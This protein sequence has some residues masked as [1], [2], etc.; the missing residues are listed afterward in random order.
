[1]NNKVIIFFG[2]KPR[3]FYH[4]V[5]APPTSGERRVLCV[6]R[7][8]FN[9]EERD[10]GGKKPSFLYLVCRLLSVNLGSV[11]TESHSSPPLSAVQ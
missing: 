10:G 9:G 5:V 11:P 8:S 2:P 4:F 3:S 7:L 6:D 1:M